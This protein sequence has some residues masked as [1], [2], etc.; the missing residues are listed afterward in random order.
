[1]QM[2]TYPE[3]NQY[4]LD[5]TIDEQLLGI[6][7]KKK[8]Y[9]SDELAQRKVENLNRI[10]AYYSSL[11]N[12]TSSAEDQNLQT[13]HINLVNAIFMHNTLKDYYSGDPNFSQEV[14]GL[15]LYWLNRVR[16]QAIM[17]QIKRGLVDSNGNLI[18]ARDSAS[19]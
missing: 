13:L 10:Y 4:D 8:Q 14:L 6:E 3:Q 18:S 15:N 5:S 19:Q 9:T 16:V 12:R 2:V 1:M 11:E 17:E 7:P